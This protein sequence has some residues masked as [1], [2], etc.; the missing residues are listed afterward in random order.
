MMMVMMKCRYYC[1]SSQHGTKSSAL[2]SGQG[3]LD[4]VLESGEILNEF[5]EISLLKTKKLNSADFSPQSNYTDRR[6]SAKLVPTFADRGC[7]VVSAT[8]SHGS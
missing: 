3:I 2:H 6:L 1:G 4:H 7:G 5:V 8:H